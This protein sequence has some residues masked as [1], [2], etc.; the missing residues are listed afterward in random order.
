MK[1][2]LDQWANV[3][4]PVVGMLHLPA[5]PGSPLYGGSITPIREAML[6]DAGFSPR[7]ASTDS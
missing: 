7:A 5:L 1:P 6:R 4:K 3:S 2:L